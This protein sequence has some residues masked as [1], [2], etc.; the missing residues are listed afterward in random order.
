ML[1]YHHLLEDKS[2]RID[3]RH[4]FL[5]ARSIEN[6]SLSTMLATN[7][8]PWRGMIGLSGMPDLPENSSK[9]LG[10]PR[11]LISLEDFGSTNELEALQK[12]QAEAYQYGLA[13][14]FFIHKDAPHDFS[15]KQSLS[16]R[17]QAMVTFIFDN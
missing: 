1:V 4:V 3:D 9:L 6:K 15:S 10:S 14:D 17:N 12:Y 7:A 5:F 2:M 13:V 8:S 16:L 11:I